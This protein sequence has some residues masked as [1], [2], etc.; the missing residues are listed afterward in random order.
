MAKNEQADIPDRLR[1]LKKVSAPPDFEDLLSRQ[2]RSQRSRN[3]YLQWFTRPVPLGLI[4]TCSAIAIIVFF[5]IPHYFLSPS[6][7]RPTG[8]E[9]PGQKAAGSV[10]IAAPAGT[11]SLSTDSTLVRKN[12]VNTSKLP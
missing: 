10:Q 12:D 9:L 4:V 7:A 6:S 3:A 5:A 11:D 8:M 2:I 1:R